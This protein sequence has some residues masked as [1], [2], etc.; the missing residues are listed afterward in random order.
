MVVG[1]AEKHVAGAQQ[2]AQI[3][4]ADPLLFGDDLGA[5]TRGANLAREDVH[6][7]QA[8]VHICGARAM[9][10]V[11]IG[12]INGVFVHQPQKADAQPRQ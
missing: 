7:G 12:D 5:E 2:I 3:R 10:A 4:M 8:G 1:T 11:E 6:L 9:H